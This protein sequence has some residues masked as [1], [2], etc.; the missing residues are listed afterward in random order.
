V[1]GAVGNYRTSFLPIWLGCLRIVAASAIGPAGDRGQLTGAFDPELPLA[2]GSFA[3]ADKSMRRRLFSDQV[4]FVSPGR[5]HY[6]ASG[7]PNQV[8]VQRDRP[9]R[10]DRQG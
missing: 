3:V 8:T 2:N 1:V 5:I 6:V 10:H 7:R 4:I 9:S